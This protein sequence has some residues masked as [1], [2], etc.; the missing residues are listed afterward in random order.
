ML[1]TLLANS[2]FFFFS[3]DTRSMCGGKQLSPRRGCECACRHYM[4]TK[5]RVS[6]GQYFQYF[7]SHQLMRLELLLFRLPCTFQLYGYYYYYH[8]ITSN[9][10]SST[11]KYQVNPASLVK[12]K[13]RKIDRSSF[14]L[15]FVLRCVSIEAKRCDDKR[16]KENTE[17]PGAA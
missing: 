5:G 3:H 2:Y 10:S 11:G 4:R 6:R 14:K 12:R 17:T 13:R 16:R 9:E 1:K 8:R 15:F 7:S